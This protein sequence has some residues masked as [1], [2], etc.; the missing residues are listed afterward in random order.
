[1]WIEQGLSRSLT[2]GERAGRGLFPVSNTDEKIKAAPI[3]IWENH[4]N[5]EDAISQHSAVCFCSQCQNNSSLLTLH[6]HLGLISSVHSSKLFTVFGK[7]VL[8]PHLEDTKCHTGCQA[9][10][11]FSPRTIKGECF[12][13]AY[14]CTYLLC[15]HI[16]TSQACIYIYLTSYLFEIQP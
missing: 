2:S 14:V 13:L 15:V 16:K 6:S 12:A 1:M 5:C 8:S 11:K 10:I 3:Y 4:H 7:D 9:V